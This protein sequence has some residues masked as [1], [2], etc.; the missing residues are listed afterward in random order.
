MPRREKE[1]SQGL[2]VVVHNNNVEKAIRRF[3][4]IVQQSGVLDEIRARQE[5]VKPSTRKRLAKQQS[6]RRARR[7][8]QKDIEAGLIPDNRKP[9]KKGKKR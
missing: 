8:M 6:I 2:R 7:Q 1:P 9:L 4:K 3:K 5:Y